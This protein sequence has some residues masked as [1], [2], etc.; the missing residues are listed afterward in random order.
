MRQVTILL[1]LLCVVS[2]ANAQTFQAQ[3][4]A[5]WQQ[6]AERGDNL[7]SDIR[8]KFRA[9]LDTEDRKLE[10][11]LEYE[12]I[13]TG[14]TNAFALRTGRT[15]LTASFL[16]VID[17]MATMMSAAEAYNKPECL[18]DYVEY[19][20]EGTRHNSWLV[21]HGQQIQPVAMAFGY[22]QQR[23]DVCGGLT[24]AT[25]R[26][27]KN[28]DDLRELAIYS[29]LI[30]LIGHEFAH[31]KYHDNIFKMVTPEQKRLDISRGRD[32][33]LEV[34][35]SE[36][37]AKEERADLFAFEKMIEMGYSPIGA[38]PV[39]VFFLGVEG[40]SPEQTLEADHPSAV[41]RFNDMI[42]ATEKDSKF[43]EI[44][45]THHIE[46]QWG[47]F[48]ALGKQLQNVN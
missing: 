32:V 12:I 47:K 20:G 42:A 16:Q 10:S 13:I 18:G 44:I 25:F 39:L 36:Q 23:P 17:S 46:E 48:V 9:V 35:P 7:I 8:P 27:N 41:V 6:Y 26:A 38:M 5:L 11:S 22:W 34:T 29:S 28:A 37:V 21:A 43:M 4:T 33:S 19:L 40:Y 31:H 3:V 24:E 30:D 14:N 15:I 1:C 45:H 2:H